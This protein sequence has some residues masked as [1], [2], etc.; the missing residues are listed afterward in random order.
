MDFMSVISFIFRW[1]RRCYVP[2]LRY[3]NSAVSL[4]EPDWWLDLPA[5][6]WL[7][8]V[9]RNARSYVAPQRWP[10]PVSQRHFR[11]FSSANGRVPNFWTVIL[12]DRLCGGGRLPLLFQY[13]LFSPVFALVREGTFAV[14]GLLFFFF[15]CFIGQFLNSIFCLLF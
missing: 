4:P 14:F 5:R 8:D 2:L 12:S 7:V 3:V 11:H 10:R 6:L 13:E 15:F 1:E 9:F